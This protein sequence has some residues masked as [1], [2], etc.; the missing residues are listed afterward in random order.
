[1]CETVSRERL[2]HAQ[3]PQMFRLGALRDA[4]RLM[5]EEDRDVTDEAQAMELTGARPRLVQGSE[6]NI[7]ITRPQDL[8]LAEMF[9]KRRAEKS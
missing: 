1:M 7:K 8:E 2:W 4:L 3:T 9:L 6:E 5:V